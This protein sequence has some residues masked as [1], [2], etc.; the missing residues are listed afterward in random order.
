MQN[1]STINEVNIIDNRNV[2]ILCT[3]RDTSIGPIKKNPVIEMLT[4]EGCETFVDYI[5]WLGLSDD[6]NLVILSSIYHYYYDAEEMKNISTIINLKELNHVKEINSF[7]HSIF[8][9][10]SP[11]SNFIG[12]FIDN[13]KG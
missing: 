4:A 12:C 7:L 8:H 3:L 11:K 2:N 10:T 6:Q 5:E 13:E 1:S 9:I